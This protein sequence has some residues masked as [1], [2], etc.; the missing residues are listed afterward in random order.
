[1]SVDSATRRMRVHAMTDSPFLRDTDKL[2]DRPLQDYRCSFD[3]PLNLLHRVAVDGHAQESAHLAEFISPSVAPAVAAEIENVVGMRGGVALPIRAQGKS[4]GVFLFLVSKPLSE[5]TVP[6]RELMRDF[7]DTIGIPLENVRLYAEAAQL[8]VTDDLTGVANRRRFDQALEEE[9][10]RARGLG[11]PV[12]LL[13]ID[14]DH[15]KSFNDR[16]GHQVGDRILRAIAQTL[17]ANVRQTDLISR[18]GGEEFTIILPGT[19]SS[20]LLAIGEKLRQAVR[21][22]RLEGFSKIPE[23]TLSIGATSAS[24]PHLSAEA[25]IRD[26]DTAMYLAKNAHDCV[27]I[28]DPLASRPERPEDVS[29]H[30]FGRRATD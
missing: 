9:I 19:P 17:S 30:P 27:R 26:A 2:L 22:L 10:T 12:G 18:Y 7:V 8:V 5:I 23:V 25:L 13:L 24:P 21:S 3:P 6:E 16:Y 14:V 20:G 1:L 15:F 29:D 28:V 11:Y 4:V